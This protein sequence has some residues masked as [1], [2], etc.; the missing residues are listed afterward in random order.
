MKT[1]SHG[2]KKKLPLIRTVLGD[3][4]AFQESVLGWGNK[5]NTARARDFAHKNHF[6]YLS[7]EDGF[8]RSMGLGVNGDEPLSLVVDDYGIYYDATKP[9]KLEKLIL[10]NAGIAPQLADGAAALDLVVGN[11]LSKYNHVTEGWPSHLQMDTAKKQ[12]LVIDQTFGDMSLKYGG[13]TLETFTLMMQSAQAENPGAELWVKIHPDVLTGKKQGH[14]TDFLQTAGIHLLS[15][16][17]HPLSLLEKMDK[18]YVATSQMGFEALMLGKEVVTFGLPWYAGWGLTDDRHAGIAGLKDAGRRREAT[19]LELFTAGYLQYCRYINPF[20]QQRGTIF[21][22]IEYLVMM[23]RR[24]QLLQGEIWCVGLSFWKRRIMMPFLKTMHNRVRFFKTPADL[25]QAYLKQQATSTVSDVRLLLWGKKFPALAD[26]ATA[27]ALPLLRMEDGFIRSVGLGSNLVPPRSLVIDDLG[28]Y[29]DASKPSRLEVIL[30]TNDFS[31][32]LLQEATKVQTALVEKRI[33]KYN[34]GQAN[35]TLARHNAGQSVILVPGQVEDDA[36]I[37]TGTV[38]IRTNLDLLKAARDSN[39]NAYIIYKP[40][41]D[42]VSGNRVGVIPLETALQYADEVMPETDILALIAE[43]DEVH[44]MTSLSGFEALLRGK[45]V[46]CYGLPFYA[47]WGLTTD[48][49]RVARR[50]ARLSLAALIAGTLLVY[51]TYFDPESGKITN[52]MATLEAVAKEKEL[53][54]ARDMIKTNWL[55]RKINQFKGLYRTLK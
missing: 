27:Q 49:H 33:G 13:V 55:Q 9:S 35:V 32:S 34:V 43:C 3:D 4:F 14:L 8:L 42:V 7:L 24:E 39:P 25:Q 20:T 2:I 16:D 11:K 18:V 12:V 17:I 38:D 41:P 31:A 37:Q 51:P 15:E 22:V 19:L 36:S 47:G 5:T 28:I 1:F 54:S 45:R 52:T 44:T 48:R 21:D 23:K 53:L 50:T 6:P 10:D 29:F 26:W 40:H 30:N 46:V